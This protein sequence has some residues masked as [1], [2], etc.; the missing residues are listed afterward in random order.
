MGAMGEKAGWLVLAAALLGGDCVRADPGYT[1]TRDV[2]YGRKAGLALT[3]DVFAPPPAK[4]NGVG[5]LAIVSGGWHSDVI[6]IA[7]PY[8]K[9]LLDSG[10]TVF[11][12]IHGSQPRFTIPDIIEDVGQAV[13]YVRRHADDYHIDPDYLG[14]WGFSA[15][16]HLTLMLGSSRDAATRV[17][18]AVAFFPPTDFLNYGK[19]GNEL[20][21]AK[22]DPEFA[23]AFDFKKWNAQRGLFVSITDPAESRRIMKD[24]SP[25]YHVTKDSAPTLFVHGDAD[26]LVPL[27]QSQIMEARLREAGVPAKLVVEKEAGH[28]WGLFTGEL[29]EDQH[30]VASWFD[31]Y[32]ARPVKQKNARNRAAAAQKATVAPAR[33]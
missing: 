25:I 2:I 15:G 30:M 22:I 26:E 12:V 28:G 11:A 16:G 29:A 5:V 9:P 3:M 27:Q 4:S 33:P 1:R 18:A 17:Q 8:Y 21:R 10:Y 20:D 14:A 32:L 6:A 7:P 24:V 23:A 13:R 31:R 19:T